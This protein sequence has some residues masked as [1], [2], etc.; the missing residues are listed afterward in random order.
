VVRER[1]VAEMYRL[2][3]WRRLLRE[4]RD[5]HLAPAKPVAAPSPAGGDEELV[6]ILRGPTSREEEL[7]TASEDLAP[8]CAAVLTNGFRLARERVRAALPGLLRG[9]AEQEPIRSERTR[10][11][12]VLG[13]PAAL[14]DVEQRVRA[15][16]GDD[17]ARKLAG[18]R[19]ALD[20]LILSQDR[21]RILLTEHLVRRC[22]LHDN[23]PLAVDADACFPFPRGDQ[24]FPR[25]RLFPWAPELPAP[26]R[27]LTSHFVYLQRMRTAITGS[28]CLAVN[29][30]VNRLE[31]AVLDQLAELLDK[32]LCENVLQKI[33]DD[34]DFLACVTGE[35]PAEGTETGRRFPI[36]DVLYPF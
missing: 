6:E 35:Q 36:A 30:E 24:R 5:G 21:S 8:V 1:V 12:T 7:P 9:L 2:P 11:L 27:E 3:V 32:D 23:A 13:F 20:P 28:A 4:M 26:E 29:R 22:Q 18:L 14:P 19:L 15:R 31:G 17:G 33:S 25:G 16:Y 10:L 34:R